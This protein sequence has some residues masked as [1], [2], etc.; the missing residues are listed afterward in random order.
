[1]TS[2]GDQVIA[3]HC[4]TPG[5]TYTVA[6]C[7]DVLFAIYDEK[8]QLHHFSHNDFDKL[9]T[10]PK[11]AEI[12]PTAVIGPNVRISSGCYIGPHCVIGMPPEHR[13]HFDKKNYG[14]YIGPGTVLAKAVVIDAGIFK[15]TA[16]GGNCFLMSGSHVG[17][18]AFL[19]EGVTLSPKAC[20]GGHASV[21]LDSVVGMGAVI[22]QR[23]VIPQRVMIGM[24]A[25][26]T[27]KAAEQMRDTETWA[28]NPARLIGKNKKWV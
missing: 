28:G 11:R 10:W 5:N 2:I 9:F 13:D 23:A 8:M 1:M 17:H 26:V 24:G 15:S 7:D 12:H 4:L 21:G 22:H 19:G 18:D 16:I 6:W 27:L 25:V 14:V 20:I 3:T